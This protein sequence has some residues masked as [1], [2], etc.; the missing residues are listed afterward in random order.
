MAV[1]G[2]GRVLLAMAGLVLGPACGVVKVSRPI[3]PGKKVSIH[4]CS[5]I[6]RADAERVLNNPVLSPAAFQSSKGFAACE[7]VKADSPFNGEMVSVMVSGSTQQ[8]ITRAEFGEPLRPVAGIG[9]E[10]GYT[11]YSAHAVVLRAIN[12]QGVELRLFLGLMSKDVKALLEDAK[13]LARRV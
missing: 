8:S 9:R 7:Y 5:V 13:L 4:P 2:R 12:D 6:N 10:A 3:H 11:E 1:R